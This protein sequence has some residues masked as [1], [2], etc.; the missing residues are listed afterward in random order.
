MPFDP[1]PAN[2]FGPG[3]TFASNTVSLTI[4]QP[5]VALGDFAT[6]TPTPAPPADETLLPD[7][8]KVAHGLSVGDRVTVAAPATGTLPAQLVPGVVYYVVAT[9]SANVI[10]ISTALNGAPV[11]CSYERAAAVTKLVG[12]V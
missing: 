1:S 5:S 12:V 11:L 7:L 10:N 3:Y 6:T 2:F 4:G 8:T 9:P